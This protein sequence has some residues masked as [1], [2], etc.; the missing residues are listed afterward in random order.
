MPADDCLAGFFVR[1]DPKRGIFL[2]ETRQRDGQ[3]V[4][5]PFVFGSTATSIT[6]SGNSI[7]SRITGCAAS[8]SVSPGGDV[9]KTRE[10]DDIAGIM[11]P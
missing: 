6:G 3:L 10:R 8:D 5:V 11:L 9:L 1:R 4:L 7:R 2:C